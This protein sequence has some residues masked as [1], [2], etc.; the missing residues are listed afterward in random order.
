[1][2]KKILLIDD[3]SDFTDMVKSNLERTGRYEV[4]TLN[5]GSL[6]LSTAQCVKP[7]LVLLDLMMPDIG[8]NEVACQIKED[9]ALNNTPIIFLTGMVSGQ[10]AD[11]HSGQIGGYPF[12]AKPVTTEKLIES[13]EEI[14]G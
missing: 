11:F 13:I 5:E 4:K 8:G 1:M 9:P 12:L 6:G 7:D 3:E 2:L 14:I 10:E